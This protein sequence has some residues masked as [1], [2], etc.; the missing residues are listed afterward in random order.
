MWELCP[1]HN[2]ATLFPLE[3]HT[4][5]VWETQKNI[6]QTQIDTNATQ[7]L[8][9]TPL[10]IMYG[11]VG[12][13]GGGNNNVYILDESISWKKVK[14]FSSPSC[15]EPEYSSR[16]EHTMSICT[17]KNRA[18]VFGGRSGLS[19]SPIEDSNLY[20]L[21]LDT[22]TWERIPIRDYQPVPRYQHATCCH[23]GKLF[24]FGGYGKY[25]HSLDDFWVF[26]SDQHAWLLYS[27]YRESLKSPEQ[28]SIT[29]E[30]SPIHSFPAARHGHQMC[31]VDGFI[32]V[33]GGTH[34][35]REAKA[36]VVKDNTIKL[37]DIWKMDVKTALWTE[38]EIK[39]E[40]KEYIPSIHSSHAVVG[41]KI[42][43]YGGETK[44]Q[45][46]YLRNIVIFD[47]V[48]ERITVMNHSI[49]PEYELGCSHH[50]LALFGLDLIVTGGK[51][52]YN[53]YFRTD[54]YNDEMQQ[55]F[56]GVKSPPQQD[57]D[58][59][60]AVKNVEDKEK[61][62]RQDEVNHERSLARVEQ[63]N[64]NWLQQDGDVKLDMIAD[65]ILNEE[66]SQY[67]RRC[68]LEYLLN[69]RG[70]TTMKRVY[71]NH[72]IQ[73]SLVRV[74]STGADRD[75]LLICKILHR[76]FSETDKGTVP[77]EI[78]RPTLKFIVSY[79]TLVN[80]MV[81]IQMQVK[82]T[83]PIMLSTVHSAYMNLFKELCKNFESYRELTP[84][85]ISVFK[86]CFAL[87]NMNHEVIND[88]QN[89]AALSLKFLTDHYQHL[90]LQV[91]NDTEFL[92]TVDDYLSKANKSESAKIVTDC[93]H[94]L[95]KKSHIV[96]NQLARFFDHADYNKSEV[97]P[98]QR[99]EPLHIE[100]RPLTIHLQEASDEDEDDEEDQKPKPSTS[101]S[102]KSQL[103]ISAVKMRSPIGIASPN[104]P[105]RQITSPPTPHTPPS[106]DMSRGVL[107]PKSP[108]DE[109]SDDE[110]EEES[111]EEAE[112]SREEEDTEQQEQDSQV[113]KENTLSP[114]DDEQVFMSDKVVS[115]SDSA[116][117]QSED[118][119]EEVQFEANE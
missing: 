41:R 76:Y 78:A 72:S 112:E 69:I 82:Y 87:D 97:K 14:T 52:H 43:I 119:L 10:L 99:V 44:E 60:S 36:G 73:N 30:N 98:T 24:L 29:I 48:T 61:T 77:V 46:E 54:K 83:D 42:V 102:S 63:E 56:L 32:Y 105:L 79:L 75:M 4:V 117:S 40:F 115:P 90:H 91:E 93:M 118:E 81:M 70:S 26:D 113:D 100:P 20:A 88:I 94:Q 5:C 16:Y 108:Y 49:S 3:G 15:V 89:C 50:K 6:H 104:S 18:Y 53:N 13:Y 95:S 47:T 55:Y 7:N 33:I 110:H 101:S 71:G 51:K 27:K 74:I 114:P 12:A 8:Q 116:L 84:E 11:G 59:D 39:E 1:C 25:S 17:K 86:M 9:G 38:I 35:S 68:A 28:L 66:R 96:E 45:T 58:K 85:M 57:A 19:K 103:T 109:D 92:S 21:V 37:Q 23:N 62:E 67:S 64:L 107:S 106:P 22:F 2:T 111:R 65:V 31:C 80:S 34:Y